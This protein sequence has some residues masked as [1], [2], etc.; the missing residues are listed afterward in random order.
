MRKIILFL[1]LSIAGTAYAQDYV[2][3]PLATGTPV[4][5]NGPNLQGGSAAV[6]KFGGQF[7]QPLPGSAPF[8]ITLNSALAEATPAAIATILPT[9]L[10]TAFGTPQFP[11]TNA[12][13]SAFI[14]NTTNQEVWC[15]TSGGTSPTIVVPAGSYWFDNYGD[16]DAKMS[17]AIGCI[18]PAAT[19][20]S[21]T[22]EIGGRS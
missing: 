14:N 10:P 5:I 15:A 21:G 11:N 6:D 9:A 3:N 1:L 13:K 19:P 12:L 18:H 16:S 7:V 4:Q 8:P 20:A 2:V 22:V 17:G